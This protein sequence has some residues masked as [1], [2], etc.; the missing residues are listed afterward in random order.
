[1]QWFG[2]HIV[3]DSALILRMMQLRK[4][5]KARKLRPWYW[6]CRKLADWCDVGSW[7]HHYRQHNKMADWLAN[8]AMDTKRSRVWVSSNTEPHHELLDGISKLVPGDIGHWYEHQHG[9]GGDT[10]WIG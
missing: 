5:P 7:R 4:P 1:M 3:G 6:A 10:G 2:I 8:Y 9:V